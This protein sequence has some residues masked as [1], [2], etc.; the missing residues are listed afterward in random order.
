MILIALS[1]SSK[2]EDK[3]MRGLRILCLQ[4]T[5]LVFLLIVCFHCMA[6]P[7]STVLIDGIMTDWEAVPSHPDPAGDNSKPGTD[8]LDFKV[9]HDESALYYYSRHSGPIVS[10]DAGTGGQ[11]RYYYLV[12]LDL[13][14]HAST[15]FDPTAWDPDC[16]SPA[17]VGCDLELTFERDW[18]D[19]SGAYV[20]QCCY[21]YAG[22]GTY[23]RN[24]LDIKPGGFLRFGPADNTA[25]YKFLSETIP[26]GIVFTN[27]IKYSNYTPGSDVFMTQAF[28]SDMTQSEI[29]VDFRAALKDTKGNP[30]L[31]F[32]K[33][34][35]LGFACES[36][37]WTDCG[38]GLEPV[39][40]YTLDE[41]SEVSSWMLPR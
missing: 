8:I 29:R 23:E 27:D 26:D 2:H 24:Q 16:Y 38:D 39:L 12:F 37:P 5:W 20:V 17:S 11:G 3:P 30:H 33:T 1:H 28:S 6:E 4:V 21:A 32:G 22:P 34:I 14:N 18:S 40:N 25:L 13:D 15:G 36:S 9:T 35:S 41:L 7:P 10:E 19:D 31:A